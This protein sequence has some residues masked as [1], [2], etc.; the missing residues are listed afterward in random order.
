MDEVS[1]ISMVV[2]QLDYDIL[3]DKVYEGLDFMMAHFNDCS[4]V[5][6]PIVGNMRLR[7]PR[8]VLTGST[9]K[10]DVVD[11]RD[12]TML[13][14]RAALYE[15]CYLNAY[16]DYEL[17]KQKHEIPPTYK[18]LPR[19]IF[20][21]IDRKSFQT[22]EE[23]E[24]AIA[25]TLL[26]IKENIIGKS[27]RDPTV[28]WSGNGYHVHIPLDGW[29][30]P[31]EELPE[32]YNFRH[33]T[34]LPDRFL[35][36]AE[37]RLS[38]GYAD[39]HH[40]PSIKSCLFRVPGTINTRAR[41]TGKDPYVRIVKGSGDF[42]KT[43]NLN[44]DLKT[45]NIGKPTTEFLNEF[46]G[47][48]I[49]E[50]IDE[51]TDRLH[52]RRHL[53]VGSMLRNG[54][55]SSS[56]NSLPWIDKLLQTSVDDSRKNLLYW[57]LAPYLMTIRGLDYDKAYSILEGWLERCNDVRRLEPDWTSFRYRIRYCLD[58]AEEQERKPIRF[59]TFKEYYPDIYKELKL[60]G[61]D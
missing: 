38:G 41:D 47:S 4:E 56:S 50:V 59:E 58:T 14:Y 9:R 37:R 51:K 18:P 1:A 21:D 25:V 57:V 22:D 29:T 8:T 10:Q 19:H 60:G 48:L 23:L 44:V 53:A 12:R 3:W 16:S 54:G 20:I 40:S 5:F 17:I 33:Y 31:L 45:L 35:R 52:H 43:L 30:A 26:N 39:Q 27:G 49:Q 36:F 34:D 42:Y 6:H 7:F 2:S 55:G 11:S 15:D 24:T 28:I 46:L 61:G 13:Y 32:F